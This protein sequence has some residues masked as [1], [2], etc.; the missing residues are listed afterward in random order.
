MEINVRKLW[1]Q[2]RKRP[3][4]WDTITITGWS[5]VGKG[6]G[7]LVPFFI[8]A[9]FGVS[10]ET[11]AFFFVY[12][13]ILFLAGILAS[14]AEN[15]IVPYIAEIRSEN[16]DVGIFVGST[17]II[18]GLGSIVLSILIVLICIPILTFITKFSPASLSL[19]YRLIIE[20]LPLILFLIWTS[21]LAGTLNAYKKFLISAISPGIRAVICLG[22]TFFFKD[23]LGVHAIVLGYVLGEIIRFMFLA[24]MIY[25]RKIFKF[26]FHLQISHKLLEFL[27]VS[28]YQIIGMVAVGFNPV[29]DRIMSS[30]LGEG[31]VSALYYADRLYMI[32]VTFM[33]SGLIVALLSH[34]SG[35]FYNSGIVRLRQDVKKALKTVVLI[36]LSITVILITFNRFLVN[37]SLSRGAF[38]RVR[39][40]EVSL[41]WLCYLLGFVP[42]VWGQ[43]Y[44]KGLLVLRNTKV[45]MKCA[46]YMNLLNI[47]FNLIL[48]KYFKN[49]G[50]AF[51]TSL[52][53][54]FSLVYLARNF[55]KVAK[56]M[57]E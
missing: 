12:G 16:E 32:P 11:D 22:I 39:L 38:D 6:A 17:L 25:Q 33:T 9:W 7:F 2:I 55:Y 24:G 20:T 49:A 21:V 23:R 50:I 53:S 30:W 41:V 31:S 52:V 15:V 1:I 42:C 48:M 36:A 4:V 5:T 26:R 18:S 29:V 44:V 28:S 56:N 34:W 40:P 57:E 14:A 37:F 8:A 51:A 35:R 46:F 13:L 45:L 54:V 10:V 43:I 47:L 3:L 19:I 27:R